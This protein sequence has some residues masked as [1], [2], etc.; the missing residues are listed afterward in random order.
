MF[1]GKALTDE[2]VAERGATFC[3]DGCVSRAREME[4]LYRDLQTAYEAT[5]EALVTSLDV[6]EQ[7]TGDH[8]R[9][10]ARYAMILAQELG[11]EERQC[12]QICRGA[13]LHDIGKI[14]VPDA[15]LLKEGPLDEAE[16]A[17]MRRHPV[18]GA[19][20]LEGVPF[21][22]DARE[23]VLTHQERFDGS[24]YPEGLRGEEI[25][26]GAR[27]FAAADVLDA[28]LSD[29]PY[30]RA[31]PFAASVEEIR[32]QAGTTLDPDVVAA[33]VRAE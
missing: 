19:R 33:V 23:I 31:M 12:Q 30:H 6:R 27:I 9:R 22:A 11:I 29:R 24:G 10:V 5:L 7:E 20:I 32:R 25:P 16:W 13:L 26:Q 18:M 2:T 17:V 28:L 21:L 15:I 3:C 4:H 8:S 1:C 14:G